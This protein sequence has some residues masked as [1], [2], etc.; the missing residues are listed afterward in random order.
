MSKPF[1]RRSP[2]SRA[3]TWKPLD[4]LSLPE[5]S[6]VEAPALQKIRPRG[7]RQSFG[8]VQ[9]EAMSA[10]FKYMHFGR[11]LCRAQARE[12]HQRVVDGDDG[13]VRRCAEKTWWRVG[14]YK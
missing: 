3:N 8:Q 2:L 1:G 14:H 9:T 4:L 10:F 12:H 5:I 11:D 6:A 7:N 13:I